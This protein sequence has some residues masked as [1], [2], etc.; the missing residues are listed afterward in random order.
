MKAHLEQNV[1]A[2]K[3]LE[4]KTTN[5]I[6]EI[7]AIQVLKEMYQEMYSSLSEDCKIYFETIEVSIEPTQ[8]LYLNSDVTKISFD[9]SFTTF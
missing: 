4:L 1:K 5:E 6:Q 9:K 8:S 2:Y 7:E 3:L